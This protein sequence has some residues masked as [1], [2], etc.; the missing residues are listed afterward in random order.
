MSP[1]VPIQDWRPDEQAATL[2][3]GV[4]ARGGAAV[5]R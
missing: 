4:N 3:G 5:K 1:I 2:P